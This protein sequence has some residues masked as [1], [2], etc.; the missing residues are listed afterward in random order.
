M[1]ISIVIP[2]YN[3]E[4]YIKKCIDSLLNQTLKPDD[5]IV[6]DD[7][8]SDRTKEICSSCNNKI[9]KVFSKEH[10]GAGPSRNF[11]A[12]KTNG[13]I[14]VFFDAD[15]VAPPDYIEKLVS[16]IIKGEAIGTDHGDEL[17]ANAQNIWAKC[18]SIEWR[19][20]PTRRVPAPRK[21][22]SNVFRAIR[23]DIF[24][25]IGGF[26]EK[27]GYCDDNLGGKNIKAKFVEDCICYHYNPSD[28]K[29]VFQSAVWIGRGIIPTFPKV[30]NLKKIKKIISRLFKHSLMSLPNGIRFAFKHKEPFLIIFKIVY[31]FGIL[32][33]IVTY[34]LF[35]R[36]SK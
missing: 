31:D 13:D 35:K 21:G 34:I 11:G 8:S 16:P 25:K 22:W 18:W 5:I 23:K 36:T 4:K 29:E 26:D 24:T 2:A 7:G 19:V 3:E 28:L 15:M 20:P 33:G 6:V 30:S 12:S 32:L 10:S 1:R 17:V 9:V 14:I 27:K